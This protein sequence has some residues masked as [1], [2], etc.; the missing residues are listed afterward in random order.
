M[1]TTILKISML[2]LLFSLMGAGCEKENLFVKP[3][4]LIKT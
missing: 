3:F 4:K 1:K 2:F